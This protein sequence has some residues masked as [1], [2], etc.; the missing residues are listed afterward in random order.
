MITNKTEI[1]RTTV[2]STDTRYEIGGVMRCCIASLTEYLGEHE[3]VS[4][5]TEVLC[6]Y[7]SENDDS[8][9]VLRGNL[10]KVRR[11]AS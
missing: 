8:G 5:G 4:E 3:R 1:E 10:W 9:F 11:F 7:E 6:K 2:R